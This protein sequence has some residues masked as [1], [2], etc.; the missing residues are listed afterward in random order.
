[1]SKLS[2]RRTLVVAALAAPLLTAGCADHDSDVSVAY[3]NALGPAPLRDP[4]LLRVVLLSRGSGYEFTG[5]QLSGDPGSTPRYGPVWVP[6]AGEL[7]VIA[8]LVQPPNDT[9]GV[10]TTSIRLQSRYHYGVT[11]QPGG[12]RPDFFCLG[13]VTGAPLR[14]PGSAVATDTLWVTAAGLPDGAIC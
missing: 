6:H 11:V 5:A 2:V 3:L 9:L 1:M 7:R 8:A 10:A 12:P 13:Q 14:R 4:A